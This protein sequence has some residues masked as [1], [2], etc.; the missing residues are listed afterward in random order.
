MDFGISN[1]LAFERMLGE[2]C[3][4]LVVWLETG[5]RGPP[6]AEDTDVRDVS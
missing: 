2:A 1:F 3:D 4:A 6:Q 5:E